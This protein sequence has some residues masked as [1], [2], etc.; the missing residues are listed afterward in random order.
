V[1]VTTTRP[2]DVRAACR[3]DAHGARRNVER[4]RDRFIRAT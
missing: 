1:T 3:S 2:G 4:A